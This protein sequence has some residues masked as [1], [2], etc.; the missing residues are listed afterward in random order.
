VKRIAPISGGPRPPRRSR[1]GAAVRLIPVDSLQAGDLEA[2]EALAADA[3][4]PNPFFERRLVIDGVDALAASG[5]ALLVAADPGGDWIGAFPV[6]VERRLGLLRL[7]EAWRHHY[8]YLG[9]PLVADGRVDQFAEELVAALGSGGHFDHLMV[10]RCSVGPVL[11]AIEGAVA[12]ERG[13]DI[14]FERQFERGAYRGREPER[15]LDWIKGK[16]RSELR[17]QRRKL[18]EELGTEIEVV[19]RPDTA[20]A[21][22]DFLALEGSGW[23]GEQG[24]ALASQDGSAD[25]F[26]RMCDS[27]AAAGRLQIRALRAGERNLAMTCD[28]ASGPTLFG[29]KS[30]YDESL[31]R[32]SPGVQLQTENFGFF[33]RERDEELFDSCA[34]PGNEMING[35]WPD[36]RK[37]ATVV[38]GPGGIR[39][40]VTRRVLERAY[41]QRQDSD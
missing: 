13:I 20:A 38:L 36:R 3:A 15:E 32:Y 29:F 39:G 19:D 1:Y 7:A 21:V 5:V 6:T 31:R 41:A 9:T 25:L 28:L 16:K 34:E 27:F 14:L 26:R 30:A 37:I 2:W 10:R 11:E 22:D 33:D 17:R 35:L 40:A 23:K 18:G 4:E 24:T 8:S 12:G